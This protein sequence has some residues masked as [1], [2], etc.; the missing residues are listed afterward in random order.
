MNKL[1]GFLSVGAAT[2][3]FGCAHPYT[4]APDAT[5]IT[6]PSTKLLNA[7]VGYV[8]SPSDL[9]KEVITPGGGGD[10]V[11][12]TPYKDLEPALFKVLTNTFRRAYPLTSATDKATIQAKDITFVFVPLIE[13]DSSSD[14]AFTWPPTWFKLTLTCQALDREGKTVW[15]KQIVG[16]GTASFSE[17]KSD[18]PLAA[19]RASEKVIVE[20][21]RALIEAPEFRDNPASPAP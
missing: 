11:K 1:F 8:I 5:R 3:L 16:E 12:Y 7:N 18:F 13:A 19:R 17:F 15:T 14:S 2:L 21:Q 9:A 6:A 20:L 10:K 4:I